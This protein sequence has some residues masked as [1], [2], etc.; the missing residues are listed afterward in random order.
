MGS[1]AADTPN[2]DTP[3]SAMMISFCIFILVGIGVSGGEI[4]FRGIFRPVFFELAPRFLW[5]VVPPILRKELRGRS[6]PH[7]TRTTIDQ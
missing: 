6:K 4:N 5:F 1:S 3:K 2:A 7:T